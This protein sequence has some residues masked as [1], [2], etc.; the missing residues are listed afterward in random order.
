MKTAWGQEINPIWGLPSL[1]KGEEE[2]HRIIQSCPKTDLHVHVEGCMPPTERAERGAS[3]REDEFFRCWRANI[4]SLRAPGDFERAAQGFVRGQIASGVVWTEAH[5]S[6]PD[7][8]MR[9]ENPIPFE[10][11][12]RWWI[13]A[14]DRIKTTGFGVRLIVDLVRL[15]DPPRAA[16]WLDL[17]FE[18]REALPGG[19]IIIGVGLGGPQDANPLMAY[20]D[21]I[22]AA[23]RQGLKFFAHAG[24]MGSAQDVEDAVFTLNAD[25]VA[26]GIGLKGSLKAR[27]KVVADR[28]A[29]ESCP[30]SSVFLG[31]VPSILAHPID[32]WMNEGILITIGSD[33]P[34]L[35]GTDLTWEYLQVARA[36][37]WSPTVIMRVIENGFMV[38]TM[39]EGLKTNY[40]KSVESCFSGIKQ[41]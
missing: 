35:F 23:R 25:R 28:V 24:E 15:Y 37:Q 31:A 36:F 18:A 17:V 41:Q 38:S 6:P 26:H 2:L 11:A 1:M 21:T 8:E 29:V 32:G 12:L 16:R 7:C 40:I 33:D 5:I 39:D 27:R 14:F 4:Q 34:C 19:E 20:R 3:S 9:D 30:T 10:T 13:E 22:S